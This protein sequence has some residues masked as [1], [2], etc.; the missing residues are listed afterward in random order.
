[1]WAYN[2]LPQQGS[3]IKRALSPS[4]TNRYLVTSLRCGHRPCG[5]IQST[6]DITIRQ[7]GKSSLMSWPDVKLIPQANKQT[8]SESVKTASFLPTLTQAKYFTKTVDTKKEEFLS[9]SHFF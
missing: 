9:E 4:A 3:A 6:N 7:S 1:M 8:N 5:V 2:M